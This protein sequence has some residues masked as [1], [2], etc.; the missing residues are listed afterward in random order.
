MIKDLERKR[1]K[2]R[3][4]GARRVREGTGIKYEKKEKGGEGKNIKGGGN[5]KR[6]KE[7]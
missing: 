6:C 5:Q 2:E 4:G 7:P 3:R 1:G